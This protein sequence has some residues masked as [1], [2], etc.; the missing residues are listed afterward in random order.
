MTVADLKQR[1]SNYPDDVWVDV[2]FTDDGSNIY[3]IEGLELYTLAQ[4]NQRV[5]IDISVDTPLR[6][7]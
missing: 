4:G 5:V 1:L 2:M 3:T 7:V 6:A